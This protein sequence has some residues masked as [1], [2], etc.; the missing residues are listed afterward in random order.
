MIR[1]RVN[2]YE[3]VTDDSMNDSVMDISPTLI[4]VIDLTKESPSGSA[5]ASRSRQRNTGDVASSVSN[6]STC[7]CRRPLSP[8]VLGNTPD[9]Q[10][11]NPRKKRGMSRTRSSNEV[12]TV[13]DTSKEDDKPYCIVESDDRQPI[14]LTCP[15]CLES[16]TSNLKPTTTRCGHLF[17]IECLESFIRISKKCPT[18]KTAITL[19]SCTRLYI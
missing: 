1:V 6:G 13:D 11:K 9:V 5:R 10:T 12:L 19:K 18:C 15:I 2:V 14:L 8:I 16:L 17:C 4:D 3:D 7:R